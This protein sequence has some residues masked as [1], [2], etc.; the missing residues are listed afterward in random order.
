MK[1]LPV[2]I[3]GFAGMAFVMFIPVC[4]VTSIDFVLLIAKDLEHFRMAHPEL[5]QKLFI[6]SILIVPPLQAI[7]GWHYY[8]RY[9]IPLMAKHKIP[10]NKTIYGKKPL[11]GGRRVSRFDLW[12]VKR[13][14]DRSRSEHEA[15]ASKYQEM[16]DINS[17][18][19][20]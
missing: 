15:L 9:L 4:V 12:V 3:A 2:V 20:I 10:S 5:M 11:F 16:L 7:C 17:K 1:N 8:T 19:A 6:M 14:L 13:A 18:A